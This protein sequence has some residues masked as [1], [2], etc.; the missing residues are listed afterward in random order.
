MGTMVG[1][2]EMIYHEERWCGRS[3]CAERAYDKEHAPG[4]E[5]TG[6][7]RTEPDLRSVLSGLLQHRLECALV[8]SGERARDRADEAAGVG[9]PGGRVDLLPLVLRQPEREHN[10]A[11]LLGLLLPLRLL[12]G[13][14]RSLRR[15]LRDVILF[16]LA[17]EVLLSRSVPRRIHE[18]SGS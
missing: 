6:A 10:Q 4:T 17:H 16:G 15:L 12:R 11:L 7:R 8:F 14:R 3:H 1:S 2:R 13:L 5:A 18:C 9:G